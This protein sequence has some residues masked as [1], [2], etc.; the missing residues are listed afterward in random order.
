MSAPKTGITAD[1]EPDALSAEDAKVELARLAK[2]LDQANSNYHANDAPTLSDAA[3]DDLK[4]RNAKIEA[5]HPSLKRADSPS[6]KVGTPIS[7][8]FGKIRHAVP[9][10]SLG[11]AFSEDDVTEFDQRIRKF[12]S[13]EPSATLQYTAEPKIDGLSLSLRY[14][15]GKLT[16]AATRGDGSVGEN[17]L[18]NARMISDIPQSIE[19]APDIF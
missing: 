12:L 4:K 18:E 16:Q 11:N 17:V 1:M 2:L 3:Y 10:L 5:L 6:D 13:I 15:N 8:G 9:M 19:N 14:E 7:D